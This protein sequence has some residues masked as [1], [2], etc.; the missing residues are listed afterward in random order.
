MA[1]PKEKEKDQKDQKKQKGGGK[2]RKRK[3]PKQPQL[4]AAPRFNC[5]NQLM[6][7]V[8]E[9]A[10]LDTR[11][12]KRPSLDTQYIGRA[13]DAPSRSAEN[14]GRGVPMSTEEP[15]G[16]SGTTRGPPASGRL[17]GSAPS[18]RPRS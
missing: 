8:I 2:G 1:E 13:T 12:R 14:S 4:P 6:M 7:T 11:I 9:R 5:S 17:P 15:R 16:V 3:P 18:A 10:D